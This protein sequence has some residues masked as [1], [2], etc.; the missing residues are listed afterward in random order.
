M[1]HLRRLE[2]A[3]RDR[4]P[5]VAASAG[6]A[7]RERRPRCRHAGPAVRR[8]RH[9]RRRA[10]APRRHRRAR[11]RPGRRP[12]RR[13]GRAAG[14][15]AGDRQV[16]APAPG[17]G[18]RRR[19]RRHGPVR[20]GRGVGVAGAAPGRAA[21][22]GRRAGRRRDPRRGRDRRRADRGPRARGHARAARD[23][24]DPDGHVGGARRPA[25]Q[26]RPGPRGR[27]AADGAREGRG[28]AGDPRGPRDEGR[29]A[30]RAED[31]RAPGRRRAL[32]RGRSHRWPAPPPRGEEPLR[33]DRGG[34]RVRDGGARPD[35]GRG[36]GPRVPRRPRRAGAGQRRRPGARGL[37]PDPRRGPGARRPHGRALAATDR[38]GRRPQP[39]RAPRRGPR[40]AGGD[41]PVGPR[42]VRE[43]RRRPLGERARP[44][45]A[46]RR[47]RSRRRS[48]TGPVVTGTVAIG[49]VGLLGELRAVGGLDRRLRE[50]A[51][52]GFTRALVP[53]PRGREVPGDPGHG[54][55]RRGHARGRRPCGA[56]RGTRCRRAANPDLRAICRVP[57][58]HARLAEPVL[59][60]TPPAPQAG[61]GRKRGDA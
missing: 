52:L 55:R 44:R 47:W 9:R 40:P 58:P 45:P 17:R 61:A 12:R 33:L 48:A 3:R 53:R 59:P 41:R 24:L 16:D 11:P 35:R 49:E 10:A 18:R 60:A 36:P 14:R 56:R 46:A 51:R 37:A 25:G 27:A 38:L 8:R 7:G 5:R 22:A 15:R 43:P 21:R 54:A 4:R 29:H 13:V 28:R 31:A 20:D 42:R 39:A 1:P 2:H 57:G 26:R 6:A 34:R 23:R 19:V 32:R 30:G 50:A